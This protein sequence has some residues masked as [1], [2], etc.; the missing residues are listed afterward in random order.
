M[1]R[2][3][4]FPV[5]ASSLDLIKRGLQRFWLRS[6][7]KSSWMLFF[8]ARLISRLFEFIPLS[9]HLRPTRRRAMPTAERRRGQL[10]TRQTAADACLSALA[11]FPIAAGAGG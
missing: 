10:C 3:L 9:N 5:R 1:H 4:N 2:Y 6:S 11:L 7:F 8:S